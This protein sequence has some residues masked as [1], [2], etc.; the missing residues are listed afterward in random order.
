MCS[1][2]ERQ[3]FRHDWRNLT[4]AEARKHCQ[5]CFKELVTVTPENIKTISQNLTSDSWVGLRKNFSTDNSRMSWSRWANGEPLIF[6]NWY[7]GWPVFKS[8][9]AKTFCSCNCPETTTSFTRF[10]ES[11]STAVPTMPVMSECVRSPMLSSDD[12]ETTTNYIED[13][14]VAMLSFGAWVEK[15]CNELLP[16][17]CYEDGFCGQ[18]NVTNITSGSA[19]L[20]WLRRPG[21][22]DRYR[23]EVRVDGEVKFQT[24]SLQQSYD[25]VNLAA[26]THHSVQVFPVKCG[27]DRDPQETAFYTIPNKVVNLNVTNVTETSVYLSWNKPAGNVT[28]YLI[29]DQDG[30]KIQSN[31]AGKEVGSLTPGKQ[32]TFTVT[33]GV[34]DGPTLSEGTNVTT[35]TKPGKVSDLKVSNNT[36]NSLWL[37][38]QR[39]EGNATGFRVMAMTDSNRTVFD[40]NVNQTQVEVTPLPTGTEITLSVTVLTDNDSLEG[41]KVTAVDYTTPEPI[42]N[43]TLETTF[44]SLN[45]TWM[46][47][48]GT[49]PSFIVEL[50]LDGKLVKPIQN[51]TEPRKSFDKLEAAANYTVIVSTFHRHVKGAEVQ[52]S[53]FT[54]LLPPT[55]AKRISSNK[56]QITFQWTAAENRA[57]VNYSV[58]IHSSFW[59]YDNSA[60]VNNTTSYTFD[61]LMSGTNYTF[62]V[63]SEAHGQTSIPAFVSHLTDAEKREV[64]LS[65]LC[66]STESLFCEKDTTRDTVFEQLREHLKELLGDKIFW[67]LEKLDTQSKA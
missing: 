7:P 57:N 17:I 28:F 51:L 35:Y 1:A 12:P 46:S 38:W 27:R 49:A 25:L 37:N 6:Q 40:K 22:I 21:D 36:I 9:S 67:K 29:K 45:A 34:G 23:V 15:N 41:D 39:P 63:R 44:D 65:M 61:N 19:N 26:G 4:W 62:E 24:N 47:S 43:L 54:R 3:Y 18:A 30:E 33:S 8:S 32:Y 56:R 50:K 10:T 64:S 58:R 16:F 53:N 59:G 5:V 55:N 48:A 20:T 2:A 42:T 31:T 66:S 14:C 11:T 13:S 52:S 60:V